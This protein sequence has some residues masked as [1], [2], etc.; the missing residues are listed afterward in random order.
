MVCVWKASAERG[1]ELAAELEAA[2][3]GGGSGARRAVSALAAAG[4]L[5]AA[6]CSDGATL[7]WQRSS[8]SGQFAQQALLPASAPA[9]VQALAFSTDASLLAAAAGRTVSICCTT[10]AEQ[11]A[12][13]QLAA[14]PAALLWSRDGTLL[15]L[16]QDGTLQKLGQPE[17]QVVAPPAEVDPSAAAPLTIGS[18]PRKSV[19]FAAPTDQPALAHPTTSAAAAVSA[20]GGLEALAAL[21]HVVPPKPPGGP[22]ALPQLPSHPLLRSAAESRAR[23]SSSSDAGALERGSG[24]QPAAGSAAAFAPVAARATSP[25]RQPLY[26]ILDLRALRGLQAEAPPQHA[27]PAAA[28][29]RPTS[30]AKRPTVAFAGSVANCRAVC[31][32]ATCTDRAISEQ[33]AVPPAS[34]PARCA[35]SLSAPPLLPT[36]VGTAAGEEDE[37]Q[38]RA[39]R[40]PAPAQ[41]QP[42][43]PGRVSKQAC[44]VCV[45]LATAAAGGGRPSSPA[46]TAQLAQLA[47]L[48]AEAAHDAAGGG[49]PGCSSRP[50]S[51][52]KL[53]VACTRAEQQRGELQPAE[54]LALAGVRREVT[55][56]RESRRQGAQG[57]PHKQPIVLTGSSGIGAPAKCCLLPGSQMICSGGARRLAAA[58][59]NAATALRP[60]DT[61][62]RARCW[63]AAST[64]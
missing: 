40:L 32:A 5:L 39:A 41:R 33:P 11:L 24:L 29:P 34:E 63:R 44:D 2:G 8:S 53:G 28:V 37:E 48:R 15:A 45:T 10:S 58:A 60:A 12:C 64:T 43:S 54:V 49:G 6:G 26:P 59:C 25:R 19:R 17:Q 22:R 55:H 7:L 20:V 57:S 4:G 16:M 18:R 52:V 9:A 46:K 36:E 50:S 30:P 42:P 23:S 38:P 51:P 31:H 56:S 62:P 14:A 13:A 21:L 61:P 35:H 27:T 47:A 1:L 3:A